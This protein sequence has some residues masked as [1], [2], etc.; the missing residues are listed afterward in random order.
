MAV[1]V[2]FGWPSHGKASTPRGA[3]LLAICYSDRCE[4][5]DRSLLTQELL[6]SAKAAGGIAYDSTVIL[7]ERSRAMVFPL[8]VVAQHRVW[9]WPVEGRGQASPEHE[10]MVRHAMA[11][12][13]RTT[14]KVKHDTSLLLQPDGVTRVRWLP[15]GIAANVAMV[16][17]CAGLW[18]GI[19]N[20]KAWRAAKR[21][22]TAEGMI[23]RGLCPGCGYDIRG[24]M[25]GVCPECG[26]SIARSA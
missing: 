7:R 17:P 14:R 23:A 1:L 22:E 9:A 4:I 12:W 19:R 16:L 10:V 6:D 18:T 11:E 13:L 3:R 25:G 8:D 26:T 21:E 5:V 24:L 20:M 2:V 15:W